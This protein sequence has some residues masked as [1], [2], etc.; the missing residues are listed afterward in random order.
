MGSIYSSECESCSELDVAAP[1]SPA[2]V[3]KFTDLYSIGE[4]LGEGGF[5]TVYGCSK[6]SG[7]HELAVKIVTHER[8][9]PEKVK[10]EAQMLKSLDHENIVRFHD[11][12]FEKNSTCI[13]M[14]KYCGGDLIE[15]MHRH[16]RNGEK[17]E[18]HD[19]V[20]ISQQMAASIQYLHNRN[21]VHRDIK[22]ENFLMDRK[23]ILD[24]QCHIALIDFGTVKHLKCD[25]ELDEQ[26]GT[27]EFW[28][29]EIYD[30]CYSLEVDV[31]AM[32]IIMYV[33]T[34][35]QFPFQNEDEVKTKQPEL[36][37]KTS[38]PCEDY[39]SGMLDKNR[40]RR[41]SADAIMIH[42]WVSKLDD[43]CQTY[44]DDKDECLTSCG[45]S[46][47]G[48][49][50]VEDEIA[51]PSDSTFSSEARDDSQGQG[52]SFDLIMERRRKLLQRMDEL[53]DV[54]PRSW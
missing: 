2:A 40:Q 14:D 53:E 8:E 42:T 31:W 52:S 49:S 54:D 33:L 17:I 6:K 25:E 10:E 23:E 20:H 43:C 26:V 22:G 44:D 37:T 4:R 5:A 39:L 1:E 29:P 3:V 13:V 50:D 45:D 9:L 19:I 15:G 18:Y 28:A 11:V 27:P 21:I 16:M 38:P 30:N 48:L 7:G 46:D 24:P 41:K 32:G 36:D 12:F 47:S 35:N 51:S 34:H